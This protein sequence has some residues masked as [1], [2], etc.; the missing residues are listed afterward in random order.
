MYVQFLLLFFFF[1]AAKFLVMPF[2]TQVSV[3]YQKMLAALT[4]ANC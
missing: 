3:L 4:I 1:L 2:P